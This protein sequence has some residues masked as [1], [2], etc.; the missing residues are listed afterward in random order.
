MT[1]VN[2]KV[3]E[4][5]TITEELAALPKSTLHSKDG[6][7]Y[8]NMDALGAEKPED[9][10]LTVQGNH[11]IVNLDDTHKYVHHWAWVWFGNWVFS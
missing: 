3:V 8:L 5:G 4:Q 7:Y 9:I 6:E 11:L 1:R 10:D 2:A